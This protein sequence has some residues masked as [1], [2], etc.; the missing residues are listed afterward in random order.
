MPGNVLQST[1]M[2]LGAGPWRPSAGCGR[3][4]LRDVDLRDVLTREGR[5]C[6]GRHGQRGTRGQDREVSRDGSPD[7]PGQA[8]FAGRVPHRQADYRPRL[9]PR[10]QAASADNGEGVHARRPGIGGSHVIGEAG[11]G[12]WIRTNVGGRQRIY[13]PSPLATRAPL[14]SEAGGLMRNGGWC[15]CPVVGGGGLAVGGCGRCREILQVAAGSGSVS[16]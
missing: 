2:G 5:I 1:G 7:E 11:G 8:T 9:A 12:G 16:R 3:R 15:Q 14:R 13:S 4:V 6:G 10:L